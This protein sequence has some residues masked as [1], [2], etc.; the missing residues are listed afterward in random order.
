MYNM[1]EQ[2]R[3]IGVIITYLVLNYEWKLVQRY[4][5]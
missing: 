5:I 4:V 2:I 1:E 3:Y